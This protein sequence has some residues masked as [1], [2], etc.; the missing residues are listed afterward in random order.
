MADGR[1][2]ASFPKAAQDALRGGQQVRAGDG[3]IF[4]FINGEPMV[5]NGATFRAAVQ[6]ANFD[7]GRR[8]GMSPGAVGGGAANPYLDPETGA[9]LPGVVSPLAGPLPVGE[10]PQQTFERERRA[11]DAAAAQTAAQMMGGPVGSTGPG[12]VSPDS[13]P[14]P[15]K[16]AQDAA[17]DAANA[18]A[19]VQ[20]QE[21]LRQ[22][23]LESMTN[24]VWEQIVGGKSAAEV[25]RDLRKTPEFAQRFPAIK[26]REAKGL[27]PLS[28][29]EYVS[30]EK[31]ARQLM[32]A[33]GMPEG[34][35][36]SN[37]DFTKY[38]ASDVS[39]AE[40]N[41]RIDGARRAA[42]EFLG[43][44]RTVLE[45]DYGLGPGDLVAFWLDPDRALPVLQKREAAAKIG[46]AGI[47][48]GFGS[49]R[50]ENED[51]VALGVTADRAQEGFSVLAQ[52]SELFA[53]IDLG[54]D[55]ITREEQVGAVFKGNAAA[56]RRIKQRTRRRQAVF[57]GGGSFAE[58]QEGVAGL[59]SAPR[60]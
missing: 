24:W 18:D 51:L 57:E 21:A 22:Y 45:R 53:P 28:P 3:R 55:A 39:P 43:E 17:R 12:V 29:G 36:D 1:T 40:L 44:E 56:E 38:L 60:R 7:G 52:G 34:L 19:F 35:Y 59:G 6:Q 23:G 47:R 5:L 15:I 11:R 48:T 58:T 37:E 2:L 20:V 31:Q 8:K 49:T 30:Y 50:A 26:E 54:E 9:Y 27:S 13:I 14:D 46:G 42:Y 41:D 4:V 33:A 25:Q 16:A 32:R 10:T